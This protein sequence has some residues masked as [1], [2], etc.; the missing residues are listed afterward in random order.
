M[1]GAGAGQTLSVTF[2]PTDTANYTAATATVEITVLKAPQPPTGTLTAA[3]VTIT[4]GG[5]TR[6]TWST[7]DAASVSISNGVGTVAAAGFLDVTPLATTTYVLTATNADGTVTSSATVTVQAPTTDVIATVELTQGWATFGQVVPQGLTVNGLVV[8]DLATQTDV[9]NRWPD[10]SIRF[11]VVTVKAPSSGSYELRAAPAP[12][13]TFTPAAVAA[14]VSLAIGGTTYTATLPAAASAD[15]WLSGPLV[16][17]DRQVV[18][19]MSGAT[20]HPFLRVNFDRARLQRRRR[21]DGRV[22]REHARQERRHDRDLRR[23]DYR[24]WRGAV[25]AG[26]RAALLPDALAQGFHRGHARGGDA[27]SRRRSTSRGRCRRT[28]PL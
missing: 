4:T 16:R 20:A 22:G 25:L 1:L 2:T 3:P 8:A 27:R 10:G 6:L 28:C 9:K 7:I 24:E 23:G 15:L 21:T 26:G 18:T 13:A 14:D 17:E 11:A 12:T 19:P 5:T